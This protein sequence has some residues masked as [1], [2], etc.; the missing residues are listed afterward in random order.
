MN[1]SSTKALVPA[2]SFIPVPKPTCLDAVF[3]DLYSRKY[4]DQVVFTICLPD[5][6]DGKYGPDGRILTNTKFSE[7]IDTYA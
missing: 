6:S 1:I 3:Y 7:F 4:R 5:E 2:K